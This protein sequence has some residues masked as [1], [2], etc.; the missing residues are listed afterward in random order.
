MIMM[1]EMEVIFWWK[2]QIPP[3]REAAKTFFRKHEEKRETA[4]DLKHTT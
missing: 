3:L 1:K 2:N 4:H